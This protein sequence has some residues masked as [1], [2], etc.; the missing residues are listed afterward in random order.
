MKYIGFEIAKRKKLV[1]NDGKKTRDIPEQLF[2][3]GLRR[4]F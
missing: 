4:N 2:L 3:C 1:R